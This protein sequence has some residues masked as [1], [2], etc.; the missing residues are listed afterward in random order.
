[1]SSNQ[2]PISAQSA[3]ITPHWAWPPTCLTAWWRSRWSSGQGL[4]SFLPN[5]SYL[6][7]AGWVHQLIHTTWQ[8]L[9]MHTV[10]V[11]PGGAPQQ[12]TDAYGSRW[13]NTYSA[14]AASSVDGRTIV[15]RLTS[16]AANTTSVLLNGTLNATG[17]ISA[18]SAIAATS[19]K[20]GSGGNAGGRPL[21][22]S[23]IATIVGGGA[24]LD[25][26]NTPAE[27]RRIVPRQTERRNVAQAL[28]LPPFS[29]AVA[30]ISV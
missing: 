21:R 17:A 4:S 1:M 8:P 19:G 22:G 23:Y 9:G 26:V 30:V 11:L 28:L 24:P 25:A 13:N 20:G 15:V 2:P 7:P 12:P 14:S 3:P 5:T 18:A 27:P 29:F 6:Q 10:W 16:W